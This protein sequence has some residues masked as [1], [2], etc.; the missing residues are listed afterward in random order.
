MSQCYRQ[1][2]SPDGIRRSR[3]HAVGFHYETYGEISPSR[4]RS[5]RFADQFDF[6]VSVGYSYEKMHTTSLV[7]RDVHQ[8]HAFPTMR[9]VYILLLVYCLSPVQAE[10]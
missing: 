9:F 7:R 6:A 5:F 3:T 10:M 2:D 4:T 1:F 8:V